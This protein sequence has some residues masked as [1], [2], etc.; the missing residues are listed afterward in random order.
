M[1]F[2]NNVLQSISE[3]LAKV[4]L[5]AKSPL[6]RFGPSNGISR[7]LSMQKDNLDYQKASSVLGIYENYF[8]EHL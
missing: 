3:A 5:V 8:F 1:T 7:S 4:D 2:R 6:C